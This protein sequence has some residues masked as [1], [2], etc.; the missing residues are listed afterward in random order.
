MLQKLVPRAVPV[1]E[2]PYNK[3]ISHVAFIRMKQPRAPGSIPS[4]STHLQWCHRASS[5]CSASSTMSRL[6]QS[7]LSVSPPLEVALPLAQ[8][9]RT[10]VNL[11]NPPLFVWLIFL[12]K[13]FW[14]SRV[15]GYSRTLITRSLFQKPKQTIFPWRAMSL[16]SCV[17]CMLVKNNLSQSLVSRIFR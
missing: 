7:N 5:W 12:Q 13:I 1:C 3:I 16:K 2:I 14:P 11:F 6:Q 17:R 9:Y 10:Q 4:S 15:W 8:A